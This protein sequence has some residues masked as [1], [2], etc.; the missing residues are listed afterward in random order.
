[1]VRNVD[2]DVTVA[3]PLDRFLLGAVT[4]TRLRREQLLGMAERKLRHAIFPRLPAD[5]DARYDDR[6]P[7]EP[8]LMLSSLRENT[9]CL[10]GC[11]Q[12]RTVDDY[13]SRLEAFT[14]GR[15]RFLNQTIRLPGDRILEWDDQR[16]SDLPLL[17]WLKYQSLEPLAWFLWGSAPPAR[18]EDFVNE[19]LDPWIRSFAESRT[20]GSHDYLRRD[21]IPH[22]VSLR[23]LHLSRYCAWLDGQG[24]LSV[25]PFVIR[26]LYK[27]AA[28]L[29][30]H[31]EYGVGGNHLVENAIALLVAGTVFESADN[32]LTTGRRLLKETATTQFLQ[33]GGHFERSPMYHLLVLRRF[34]T[35]IDVLREAGLTPSRTVR[36]TAAEATAF[37][38]ALTPPNAR[39]PLLNDA[40]F[41]ETLTLT[42]ARDYAAAVGVEGNATTNGFGASGY[43]W[44]GSGTSRLLVDGGAVGPPHLPGH[45]HVDLLSVLLWVDGRQVLTDT[46]VHQYA[47]DTFRQYARSI[48][49]HNSVQVGDLEPIDIGGQYLMGRR[50]TPIAE[51][52]RDENWETF[53]GR[54]RSRSVRGPSYEHRRGIRTNG[55]WWLVADSVDGASGR[56]RTSRLHFHPDVTLHRENDRQFT[57][58][59][60]D[61][62]PVTSV[63]LFGC[64]PAER[65]SSPYFP[66]FGTEI[67]RP[68]LEFEHDAAIAGF[69]FAPPGTG[70]VQ[71]DP[72]RAT[73]ETESTSLNIPDGV[74]QD[75]YDS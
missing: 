60:P 59:G 52:R 53:E 13:Q 15:L 71:F 54:Y 6:I 51:I 33:D 2:A 28:F 34:L 20:I 32:W 8:T 31:V 7:D 5:F 48:R 41:G 72:E 30:N 24:L 62:E 64:R 58:F 45:S 61:D 10:S 44:L 21:W 4:V 26:Y 56:A 3:G 42:E 27:N 16:L 17:W 68:A 74:T 75:L 36:T 47:D 73:V 65:V 12:S 18:S 55:N 70:P 29:E 22:A 57:V 63:H 66:E 11:L 49:A 25:R 23:I 1:M 69:L 40:V 9:R 14:D 50:T 19:V 46:G 35:A 43:Y 67:R 37:V 38:E 39:M